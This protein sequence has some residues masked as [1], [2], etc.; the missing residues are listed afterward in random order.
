MRKSN[1]EAAE[2]RRAIVTAAADHIRR[3]GIA[4]ASLSDVMAAAG[5]THGGFYKHFR[6]R[7]Q[8]IAE[9]LVAAGGSSAGTLKEV[10]AKKGRNAALDHY[11]SPEHRDAT[12]P[13]CPMAA[14]GSEAARSSG[15][16]RAAAAAVIEQMI[17]ALVED[18]SSEEARD[19]AMVDYATMIGAMTLARIMSGTPQSEEILE[20]AR[21]RLHR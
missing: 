5:L 2:T 18:P 20:R 3:T 15:E 1:K 10:R 13:T 11:L 12:T 14:L 19:E 8:L 6:N 17:D 4:E 16:T 21:R 7:E 9:A